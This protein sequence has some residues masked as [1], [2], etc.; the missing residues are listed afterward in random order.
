MS[1]R[2][3]IGRQALLQPLPP[4]RSPYDY[5]AFALSFAG[6]SKRWT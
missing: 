3:A 4:P 1:P 2:V 6:I 5:A